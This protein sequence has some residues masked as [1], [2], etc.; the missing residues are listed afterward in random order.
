MTTL[1]VTAPRAVGRDAGVAARPAL[2]RR[3]VTG[4]VLAL[5]LAG[6][7]LAVPGLRPAVR[8]IAG[9]RPA[10]AAAAIG[11]EVA[12]CLSFVAIFRLF[13]API[14]TA[15][16][17][18]LAWSEMGSGALL[19]G[20]GVGALAIGGWLLRLEGMSTS[21][22]VKR[23]SGLFFLTSAVNVVTLA[24]GGV[25]LALGL[26]GGPHDALRA[27]VPIVGA[28]AAVAI[29]L[30]VPRLSRHLTR[31][32]PRAGWLE[33][34]GSGVGDARSALSR[35]SWRLAG[36]FGYLLFDIGVLWATFAA[37]GAAVPLAPLVVAY[38]V[39]YLANAIPI[40]GGVGVL[41][42][43]LVGALTLY[44]LPV[45]HAAAAVLV[46]HAIAFWIPALGGITGYVR[47]QRR[48]PSAG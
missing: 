16:A 34:V 30:G 8:D 36:A 42:A 26:T 15:A 38:I 6:V 45:T 17:R 24:A 31:R 25:L 10:L 29:A 4:V 14:P 18:D 11:L 48:R 35:P 46:Y 20:G 2:R 39:G 27:G 9:M 13:F 23:S 5:G 33:D 7:V 28:V 22:I 3:L 12:S 41:D 32:H 43:G 1:P 47:L 44:G 40:P 21:Q 19:P 37:T